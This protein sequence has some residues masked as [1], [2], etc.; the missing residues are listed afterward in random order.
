MFIT[1][2]PPKNIH[3]TGSCGP[4]RALVTY[5][6][7][8]NGIIKVKIPAILG[9]STEVSISFIGRA[10][11]AD[12]EWSVPAVGSQI[13]VAADDLSLTNVFWLQTDGI[14]QLLDRVATLE[15]QV[16]ALM[17]A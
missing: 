17:E 11:Q 14:A 8:T 6:N 9:T 2:P 15:A 16:A 13:V 12:G 4:Y 3:A 1:N 10:V 7:A 5:S